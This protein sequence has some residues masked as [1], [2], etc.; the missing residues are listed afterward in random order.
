MGD[1]FAGVS[2]R[3]REAQ[4][5]LDAAEARRKR[6]IAEA[7]ETER[8]LARV[9]ETLERDRLKLAAVRKSRAGLRAGLK[10]AREMHNRI[11]GGE[12]FEAFRTLRRKQPA[13]G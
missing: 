7:A 5:E 1:D 3:A 13:L 6:A 10:E 12:F 9:A 4:E 11:E 8:E 2:A